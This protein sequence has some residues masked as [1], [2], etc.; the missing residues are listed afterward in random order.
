MPLG[1]VGSSLAVGAACAAA[2]SFSGA[3][4]LVVLIGAAIIGAV[5]LAAP[6]PPRGSVARPAWLV[7]R[8]WLT[9]AAVVVLIEVAVL[10]AA[11]DL[12]WPT[13]SAIQDPLTTSNPVGRLAAGT[14]WMAA[15][16]GLIT[17]TSRFVGESTRGARLGAGLV[18]AS[19]LLLA[20]RSVTDGPM[21]Q[22]RDAPAGQAQ[23]VYNTPIDSWPLS[24]W[25]TIGVFL[26]LLDA[27]VCIHR[28]GRSVEPPAAVPDL[29]AWFMAAVLG[30]ILIY[31]LWVWS[32]WH[33]LAR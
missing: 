14:A 23:G 8:W 27:A 3:A 10:L 22:S 32:G 12:R 25:V 26:A 16:W 20:A 2:P 30:R 15:G 17:V 33:F 5:L 24:T 11:D 28:L 21:R 9:W 6:Y 1:R 18:C 13:L 29:V 31:G 19:L 4:L 7:L